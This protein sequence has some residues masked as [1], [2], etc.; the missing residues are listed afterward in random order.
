MEDRNKRSSYRV[1]ESQVAV[2]HA[3]AVGL[4]G[5]EVAENGSIE[6]V[7]TSPT[8]TEIR[9]ACPCGHQ[10]TFVCDAES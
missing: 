8:T 1:P 3:V 10:V 6:L 4:S 9:F 2:G 5:R 7:R